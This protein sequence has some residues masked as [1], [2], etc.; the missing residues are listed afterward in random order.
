MLQPLLG[1]K[2]EEA[3]IALLE[4]K[5]NGPIVLPQKD[6]ELIDMNSFKKRVPEL[7]K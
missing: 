4:A 2:R 3:C 1:K 7:K 5:K 6:V